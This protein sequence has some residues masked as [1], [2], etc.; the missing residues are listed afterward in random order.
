SSPG[1]APP[2][3]ARRSTSCHDLFQPG[4]A[5]VH[6]AGAAAARQQVAE[7]PVRLAGADPAG[8]HLPQDSFRKNRSTFVAAA[9]R[10][11]PSASTTSAP[12]PSIDPARAS[13]SKSS[14]TSSWPGPRKFD[15]AP[16]GW[17]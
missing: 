10:S 8:T 7:N 4:D 16:P 11:V 15:E 12:E 9:S 14:G 5:V 2:G 6:V 13:K 3:P 17:I 1:P